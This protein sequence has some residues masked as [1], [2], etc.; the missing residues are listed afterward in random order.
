MHRIVL[1]T[2]FLSLSRST[3]ADCTREFLRNATTAYVFT[4]RY[5]AVH[6]PDPSFTIHLSSNLIYT[7]NFAPTLINSSILSTA[8]PITH[9]FSMHDTTACSTFTELIV[10][11]TNKTTPYLIHTRMLLNSNTRQV[12]TI[13]SVVTTTGDWAFNVTGYLHY[14]S[15]ENW[16]PIPVTNRDSRAVIQAAGDAYFYRFDNVSVIVPWGAPCTRIEGGTLV[17]GTLSG[18]N[19]TMAWPST[20]VV[21]DRRY[22]VD[23]EYGG[24]DIF[25]GFPGLDRSQGQNPMPDSHLFRVE[26]GKIKYAHTVSH[27]VQ[28]GCGMDGTTPFGR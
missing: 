2:I 1:A 20:I 19:C 10:L 23:E 13:E 28:K 14:S 27:C 4:Q 16:D 26:G 3:H 25:E 6:S 12:T 17:Q 18:D 8:L 7:E 21:T 15:L 24:V 11:P 5:G 22:V 9:N